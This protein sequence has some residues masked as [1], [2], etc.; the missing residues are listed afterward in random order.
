LLAF[1]SF[2]TGG[3][4]S[5]STAAPQH[6]FLV[7][8]DE[9]SQP[10]GA[11]PDPSKWTYDLGGRGWG[12]HE[13]ENYTNH[14]ENARIEKGNLVITAQKEIYTGADGVRR[15]YTSARLKTQGLFH[16]LTAASKRAL[17]YQKGIECGPR[18]GCWARIFPRQI[19]QSAAR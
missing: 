5:Q 3:R 8:H 2:A 16:N 10:D 19:G 11:L 17:K 4:A 9:F 13:L 7:W 12:N 14:L 15:D 18:F 6:Y 1:A